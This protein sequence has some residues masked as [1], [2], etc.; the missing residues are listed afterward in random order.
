MVVCEIAVVYKSIIDRTPST[1]GGARPFAPMD[2]MRN[3]NSEYSEFRT[4]N[5]NNGIFYLFFILIIPSFL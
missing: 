5:F 3:F 2:N 1:R 4:M